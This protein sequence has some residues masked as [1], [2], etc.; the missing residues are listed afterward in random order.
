MAKDNEAL[1]DILNKA[2]AGTTNKT[3]KEADEVKAV[4]E[5]KATKKEKSKAGRSKVADNLKKKAR[6]VFYSDDDF[7]IIE[8]CAD[9]LGMDA[10]AFMQMCINQKVK[11]MTK[12]NS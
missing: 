5:V 1:N 12:E 6:Q 8:E 11:Q 10:K 3:Y 7:S 4:D 2:K 9:D